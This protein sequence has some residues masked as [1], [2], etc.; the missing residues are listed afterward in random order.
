MTDKYFDGTEGVIQV[1]DFDYEQILNFRWEVT[2]RTFMLGLLYPPSWLCIPCHCILTKA[3]LAD[4]INAQHICLTQDGIRY[5]VDKH[6]TGC[7]C[8]CQDQG[9][10]TKTVPYDKLTDCDVEEPAGAEG[11]ICC[12]VQRV[13]HT[14]NVDTASGNRSEGGHELA[15]VG[16]KEPAAFKEAVWRLK[17][18]QSLPGTAAPSQQTMGNVMGAQTVDD[19]E[20]IRLLE[21]SNELLEQIAKNT[22]KR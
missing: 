20:F 11:P 22:A 10:V 2:N 12:M 19:S 5:V 7:R 3:N 16:L 17:R 15:V 1:F 4:A 18:G 6:K 14:V 21:K 9:K 8:D 13:L